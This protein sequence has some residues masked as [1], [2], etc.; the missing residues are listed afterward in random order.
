MNVYKNLFESCVCSVT[1]YAGEI[2]GFKA[3]ET[4]RQVQLKGARAF[5]GVSKQTPIPGL[6]SDINWLEPR[7]RTQVQMVRHFHRMLKM[8]NE[9]LTKKVY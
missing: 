5:L 7:S 8:D 4:N 9:R 3:Y 1:D 6:L 2:W